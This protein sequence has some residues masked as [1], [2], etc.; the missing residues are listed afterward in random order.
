MND[1]IANFIIIAA[2][3]IGTAAFASQYLHVNGTR[4]TNGLSGWTYTLFLGSSFAWVVYGANQ[5][6]EIYFFSSFVSVFIGLGILAH[7]Y[8]VSKVRHKMQLYGFSFGLVLA[9]LLY[10]VPEYSGWIGMGYATLARMPQYMHLIKDKKLDGLSP[11][12]YFLFLFSYSLTFIYAYYYNLTPLIVNSTIAVLSV[13]FLLFMVAKKS[14]R[15][16]N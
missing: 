4:K 5:N 2:T 13:V 16:Y 6:I 9:G 8:K 3:V 1:F 14:T 10:F 12:A 11:F 7:L 15:A